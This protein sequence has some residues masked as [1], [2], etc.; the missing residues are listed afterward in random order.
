MSKTTFYKSKF[1][2]AA[3]KLSFDYLLITKK[4]LHTENIGIIFYYLSMKKKVLTE[5]CPDV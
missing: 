2:N 1:L 4:K 5:T 3:S